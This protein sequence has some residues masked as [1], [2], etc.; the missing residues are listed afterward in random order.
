MTKA[1]SGVAAGVVAL[2]LWGC[3]READKAARADVTSG[4][5]F[6]TSGDTRGG[7]ARTNELSGDAG[8]DAVTP[9]F[10]DGKPIWAASRGRSAESGAQRQF[11][12]NGADFGAAKLDDYIAKA[13]AFVASA[14]KG[15]LT[16]NRA[17][18]DVLYYDPKA[19]VFAVADKNGAP[20]T[21]FKPRDGMA[22]WTQQQTRLAQGGSRAPGR[23]R[24]A[25]ADA[26]GSSGGSN[27]G[28]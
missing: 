7:A 28:G 9:L 24:V 1:F 18:G 15:V 27:S 25:R 21:M 26:S 14:P 2:A 13:H 17:N 8:G 10:K 19:N 23:T 3:G 11:A 20:R 4:A 22:Y 12:R 5:A 16:A 6:S